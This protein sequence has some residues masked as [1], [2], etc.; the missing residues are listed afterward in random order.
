MRKWAVRISLL[1]AISGACWLAGIAGL[2]GWIVA[3]GGIYGS[4]RIASATLISGLVGIG[5]LL[6][7]LMP[8][9]LVLTWVRVTVKQHREPRY[10]RNLSGL[11]VVFAISGATLIS[12]SNFMTLNSNGFESFILDV[13]LFS[14][15]APFLAG[16]GAFLIFRRRIGET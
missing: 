11:L 12:L 16:L 1:L 7:G 9:A 10:L 14:V 13:K 5:F 4:G 15:G 8:L 3:T 2:L 6:V